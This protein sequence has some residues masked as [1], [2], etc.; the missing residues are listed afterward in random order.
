MWWQWDVIDSNASD[1]K[2]GYR[3]L[4][5]DTSVNLDKS[6]YYRVIAKNSTGIS[7]PSEKTNPVVAYNRTAVDEFENDSQ[8][9]AKSAGVKFLIG[10]RADKAKEDG[11]RL[12]GNSGEYIIYKLPQSIDSLYLDVFF[13]TAGRDSDVEFS[14]G[15]TPKNCSPIASIREVF[16]P[17]KNEYGYYA[18]GRYILHN[19]P[20]EHRFVKINLANSIQLSRIE[21][22]Y[23]SIK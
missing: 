19:I 6:Y 8:L 11:S 17:D 23:G 18:A 7:E 5:S 10:G 12:Q 3:P 4:F 13:T 21:I 2:F 9:F 20:A 14:T 15:T 22:S 16:E 1:A